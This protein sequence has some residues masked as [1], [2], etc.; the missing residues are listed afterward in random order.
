M[1]LRGTLQGRRPG[2]KKA[3]VAWTA[4]QGLLHEGREVK[5]D[6]LRSILQLGMKLVYGAGKERLQQLE[7]TAEVMQQCGHFVRVFRWTSAQMGS[8]LLAQAEREYGM[9]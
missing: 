1:P 5:P 8:E 9:A 3:I 6:L 4:I 7:A 2:A